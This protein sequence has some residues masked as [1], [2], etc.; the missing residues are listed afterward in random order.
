MVE[1]PIRKSTGLLP[2]RLVP[3]WIRA[4]IALFRLSAVLSITLLTSS[5]G[6][7][8]WAKEAVV[9]A[10]NEKANNILFISYVF[11]SNYYRYII[12]KRI[13]HSSFFTL[14]FIFSA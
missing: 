12:Y 14:Y 10:I 7:A 13:L 8:T 4:V 2:L 11:L 5:I 6:F 3:G 9:A 1:L